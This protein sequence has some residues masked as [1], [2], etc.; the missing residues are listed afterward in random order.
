[1][2][3]GTFFGGEQT[4]CLAPRGLIKV[5]D[6][7]VKIEEYHS[8]DHLANFPLGKVPCFIG[9]HG[10]KLTEVTAIMIYCMH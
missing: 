5:L 7:D 3:Q 2:S 9:D 1:M 8:K 6:L 10:Y 4:R